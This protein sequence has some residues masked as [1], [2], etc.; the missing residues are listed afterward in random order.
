M[1]IARLRPEVAQAHERRGCGMTR[2]YPLQGAHDRGDGH[3]RGGR[4]HTLLPL[5]DCLYA[6]QP[7][8]YGPDPIILRSAWPV[9]ASAVCRRWRAMRGA[10]CAGHPRW[11]DLGASAAARP[12]SPG[13]GYFSRPVYPRPAPIRRA[14]SASLIRRDNDFA[15]GSSGC[16]HKVRSARSQTRSAMSDKDAAA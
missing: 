12:V 3:H 10:G 2:S 15:R 6:F 11:H 1:A 8:I 9:T 16:G 14:S 4:S 7:T 13:L 5:D